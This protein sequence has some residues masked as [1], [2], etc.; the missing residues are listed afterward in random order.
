MAILRRKIKG[1]RPPT[2]Y[3]PD[4]A[5]RDARRIAQTYTL[6]ERPLAVFQLAAALGLEV[7]KLPLD[8]FVSGYLK[9]TDG[10]WIIG[11]NS[12]HHPNRQRFTVAH[13]LGHYFLHRDQ[14]PFED[15]LLFRKENQFNL[16]EREAN[17]FAALLLMPSLDFKRAIS[18]S[19]IDI[20]AKSFGVSKQAAEYRSSSVT[21]EIPID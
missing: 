3:S 14:G 12:L 15:G 18:N 16:R 19:P 7:E 4:G 5:A 20:V 10:R 11:V 2:E 6:P 1:P 17:E 21:S 8:E 13:E 9:K